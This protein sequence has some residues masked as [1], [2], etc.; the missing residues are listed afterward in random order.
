MDQVVLIKISKSLSYNLIVQ[1]IILKPVTQN[2]LIYMV[3]LWKYEQSIKNIY[4]C[5][6]GL[7]NKN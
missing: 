6:Y 2:T 4:S 5:D 7:S 3:L 1:T